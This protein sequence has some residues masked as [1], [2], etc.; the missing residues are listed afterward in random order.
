MRIGSL[1]R[2][3][4]PV[5]G[6]RGRTRGRTRPG[7]RAFQGTF[8][9]LAP[10]AVVLGAVALVI[11]IGS[12]ARAQTSTTGEVRG[13]VVDTAGAPVAA[14]I[15]TIS[16]PTLQG[17]AGDITGADG[18]YEIGSL[19][20]GLYTLTISQAGA[21]ISRSNVLVQ[22][23]KVSRVNIR[24]QPA[25]IQGEVI[26]I[27]GRAPM[28]D[29]G[30]TKIGVTL[31]E[32]DGA[33]LPTGRNFDALLETAPGAQADRFGVSF[34]GSTS[35]ENTYLIDG[36]NAT[37]VGF[38]LASLSLP[39]EFVQEM[40]VISGGYGADYGRSSGGVV[41][42]I[43]KSG[44]N[45]LH[46]S[47]FG[48][49]APGALAGSTR[50]L[51]NEN[52]SIVFHRNLS[53]RS[54]FGAELGG[55]L[56]RDK[57]WFHA[58]FSPSLQSVDTDRVITRFLDADGNQQ[59]DRA[60]GGSIAYQEL[61]R[62]TIDVPAQVYYFTGKV[63]YAAS[64]EHRGWVS[65]FGNPS[66]ND[67]VFDDFAVGPDETLFIHERK[68]VAAG[69]AHW[70]SDVLDGDGQFQATFGVQRGRDKQDPGL[71]GGELQSFRFQDTLPLENFAQYEGAGMPEACLNDAADGFINCP[72][73]N[74]QVGGID[75][76]NFDV[77]VR[78]HGT[79]A[80]RHILD[81]LGRH[82]VK[83]GV[84]VEDN[85]FDSRTDFSGGARWWT[86]AGILPDV[87]APTRWRFIQP[88]AEGDIAC[89]LDTDGDGAPDGLCS[90]N[91]QGRLAN[92]RTL[93]FGAFVQDSWTILPNLTVEL[94]LRYE[95]QALGSA[96]EIA[97]LEDPFSGDTVGDTA[98]TLN[99]IAPRAGVIYD[100][101]NEGRSRLFGHW[102]RYFESVP[103]DL[104]ARGFS[105]ETLDITIYD[106]T[107]C[108]DPLMDPG[109]YDCD[110]A[111]ALGVIQQGGS[112]LVAPG[113]GGQY[114][115]EIVAGVEYEPVPD[116]KVGAIYIHR[117]LGRA[118]EDVA[119]DG[120]TYV[121]ANPGE[122]DRGAVADLR[123]QA[124]AARAGGDTNEAARLERAAN[125]YEGVGNFDRPRRVYDALELS[126]VKRFSRQW[127]G[128]LSYTYSALRGNFAGLFSPDT[129][130]LDPNFTSVYDLPEL[131]FNRDGRLPGD[132][133]HQ[134][135]LDA[136]YQLPV[137]GVG[138]FV[139]G[140]RARGVSGRPHN[141]LASHPVYGQGEA[142]LLPR[143]SGE[144]NPFSTGFDL[145][146]A[147]G[148]SLGG[149]MGVELFLSVF[150]VLN[151]QLTRRRDELYTFD[152]AD[153]IGGGDQADLA[154]AK[155][156][157]SP[158]GRVVSK[159]PNFDN[160][161]ELQAPVSIRFGARVTF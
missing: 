92:T 148:R 156:K 131:M 28:I 155:N 91:A 73:T 135:K 8:R 14:A 35:P 147:Y 149:G 57:L 132:L 118:I 86:F 55:P 89:G 4:M 81:A 157:F 41:N 126:L 59:P 140:G 153:P 78:M 25:A 2:K 128:R 48:Y 32:S 13:V 106:P 127:T 152:I 37:D 93:N 102:G 6:P 108:S 141:Y 22:L 31:S 18:S 19:P 75:F 97:G 54:D 7:W 130:Q 99:N 40:E 33:N 98:V 103:M 23:G 44:S 120:V 79:L 150:N 65:M 51:P 83:V 77:T 151:Q 36:M 3:T 72:V 117:D 137:E 112:K 74:Y 82:R 52:N 63:T 56:I 158:D 67:V 80:Y 64:P 143:G 9:S 60:P 113:L 1:V 50:F 101:T 109:G 124:E 110:A 123:E 115:D 30:S 146:L 100:W 42:V 85:R 159:N 121:L 95:R 10:G 20:P 21:Q 84:D 17:T 45:E 38:G 11:L 144:R 90:E 87:S 142:F 138:T 66:S 154:H 119:P 145:Q 49:L 70:T 114:M 61:D 53:Y 29:Q 122:V 104:N 47:V 16:G 160:A 129:E 26:E 94:G 71:P 12:P 24:F 68:G 134:V 161:T 88:D 69:V 5:Q 27:R 15:V 111:G 46:G 39:M 96:D 62:R 125:A 34:N 76:F 136:Y 107:T 105:G 116:L 139:F 58:G 43:T 133:P